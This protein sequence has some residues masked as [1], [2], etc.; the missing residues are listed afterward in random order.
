MYSGKRRR[1][2]RQPEAP[3]EF[4]DKYINQGDQFIG[5]NEKV[6]RK[7][8][9][10]TNQGQ[11]VLV[12]HGSMSHEG[13]PL[14]GEAPSMQKVIPSGTPEELQQYSDFLRSAHPK[15][16]E[17]M[18]GINAYN[19][20]RGVSANDLG[21][22]NLGPNGQMIFERGP[23]R[24]DNDP[25]KYWDIQRRG[26][27][28]QGMQVPA[29]Q[30]TREMEDM[31][32][33]NALARQKYGDGN[34]PPLQPSR[35][36]NPEEFAPEMI[37]DPVGAMAPSGEMI[38]LLPRG[39]AQYDSRGFMPQDEQ[40][41]PQQP[42]QPPVPP[43][44]PANP[45]DNALRDLMMNR[46]TG[47]EEMANRNLNYWD[48][49][50]MRRSRRDQSDDFWSNVGAPIAGGMGAMMK[51]NTA[52]LNEMAAGWQDQ[53]AA[54][55][56]ERMNLVNMLSGRQNKA[57]DYMA[58]TDPNVIKNQM[59]LI[60]ALANQSRAQAYRQGVD[61]NY[62]LGQQRLKFIEMDAET[63]RMQ[64]ENLN[65]LQ[66]AQI[67]NL[68]NKGLIDRDLANSTI[69]YRQAQAGHMQN[70]DAQAAADEMG[71][72][73]RFAQGQEGLDRR[74]QVAESGMNSRF[75]QGQ[76]GMNARNA[77]DNQARSNNMQY[78]Q[79]QIN[80][81]YAAGMDQKGKPKTADS[82]RNAMA[83]DPKLRPAYQ[84]AMQVWAGLTPQQRKANKAGFIAKFG[85]DPGE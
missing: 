58:A 45:P 70:Q 47:H 63:R 25:M 37:P 67:Q 80:Q 57:M 22:M 38:A 29:N 69:A 64:M 85:V 9:K 51:Q 60:N 7:V 44:V 43:M 18:D 79:E 62:D 3:Q 49:D 10:W 72:N 35:F 5:G 84:K 36:A 20:R 4:M 14:T 83:V 75:Q 31:E 54:R 42:Q 2:Q 26:A 27:A 13:Q 76:E 66:D 6:I 21:R 40:M 17:N 24:S 16:L 59:G 65:E 82:F 33:N 73:D 23:G 56:G 50:L 53:A 48:Q 78:E 77:A 81:R 46:M 55:R 52:G 28:S 41:Q 34:M 61:N 74:Q 19:Q 39:G 71:R 11:P 15:L 32:R 68:A 30:M 12:W 8:S 1:I